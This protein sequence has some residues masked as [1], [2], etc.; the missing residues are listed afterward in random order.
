MS[1]A[2]RLG[3]A[4]DCIESRPLLASQPPP[5][6][7]T[8]DRDHAALARTSQV[9][10]CIGPLRRHTPRAL[11]E[12]INKV[13]FIHEYDAN[14]AKL[15]AVLLELDFRSGGGPEEQR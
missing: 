12:R 2:G 4:R 1:G 13:Q 6:C 11:S 7:S 9:V 15:S 14:R 3:I 10:R 8:L 5:V